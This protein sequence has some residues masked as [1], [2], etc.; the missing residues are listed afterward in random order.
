MNSFP[1][2]MAQV[3]SSSASRRAC[4]FVPQASWSDFKAVVLSPSVGRRLKAEKYR[5]SMNFSFER[6][7]FS[8]MSVR[9]PWAA[10][11]LLIVSPLIMCSACLRFGCGSRSHSQVLARSGLPKA[12]RK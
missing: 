5:C 7:S 3:K 4:G 1:V 12:S 6:P 10:S 8:A 2:S 11:F 9:L